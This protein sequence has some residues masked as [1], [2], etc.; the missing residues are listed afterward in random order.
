MLWWLPVC[1]NISMWTGLPPHVWL[2]W[3]STNLLDKRD[4]RGTCKLHISLSLCCEVTVGTIQPFTLP[5][6]N[7]WLKCWLQFF[8]IALWGFTCFTS[9]ALGWRLTREGM[10]KLMVEWQ[11]NEVRRVNQDRG[12]QKQRGMKN[13]DGGGGWNDKW[14]KQMD[15]GPNG[16]GLNKQRKSNGENQ[17]GWKERNWGQVIRNGQQD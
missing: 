8:Q 14:E 16:K 1:G 11:N 9:K 2:I 3:S 12:G 4:T 15:N 10:K 7:I 13:R 5:R 6:S 17:K